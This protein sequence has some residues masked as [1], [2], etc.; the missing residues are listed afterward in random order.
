MSQEFMQNVSKNNFYKCKEED[1]WGPWSISG[2]IY[3]CDGIN[4]KH[5]QQKHQ[6]DTYSPKWAREF[7]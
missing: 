6:L 7:I 4:E 3:P 2:L 5:T 1:N